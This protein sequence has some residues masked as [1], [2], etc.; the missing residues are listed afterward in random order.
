MTRLAALL[1][2]AL[3]A[4]SSTPPCENDV[5]AFTMAK[6]LVENQL[7][8]PS[9]ADFASITDSI[10]TP[11]MFGGQCGFTVQSHVDAQNGFGGTIRQ[12]FIADVIPDAEG[13]EWTLVNLA[14]F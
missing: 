8:S 4:C 2:L 10:I 1:P 6:Q 9:S 11:Q 3:A 14:M 7:R 12:Q 13:Q 5:M